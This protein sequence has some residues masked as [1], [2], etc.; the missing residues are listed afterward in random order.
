VGDPDRFRSIYSSVS[1]VA[2]VQG[3]I[4][5]CYN[6]VGP[7]SCEVGGGGGRFGGQDLPAHKVQLSNPVTP[8]TNFRPSTCLQSLITMP[9][10]SR[11][12]V[13]WST[14]DYGTLQGRRSTTV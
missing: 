8:R 12:M 10:L 7:D 3:D 1:M 6:G 2:V 9:P 5:D 11:S 13:R 4:I 14:W